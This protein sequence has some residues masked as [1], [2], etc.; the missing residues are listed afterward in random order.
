MHKK[1][2][3]LTKKMPW[4]QHFLKLKPLEVSFKLESS[5]AFS[6]KAIKNPL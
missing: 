5:I 6:L 3:N 2:T 1:S 4:Q